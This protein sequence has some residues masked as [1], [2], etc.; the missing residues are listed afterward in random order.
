MMEPS[1]ATRAGD[2]RP[3]TWPRKADLFGVGVSVTTYDEAVAVILQAA[4]QRTPGVV[5]CQAV[6]A[7]V[8]A[9]CEAARRDKVNAC[10]LVT[11]DGPPVRWA[12]NLLHRARLAERVY[13][14]ELMLRLCRGAAER[15]IPIYLYGGNPVVAERLQ[16]NLLAQFP[17]LQIA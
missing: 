17:R 8:T 10:D 9:S 12:L 13:G 3:I 11:P 15:G 2:A 5:S 7:V 16:R 4:E 6:H 1:P 14:P